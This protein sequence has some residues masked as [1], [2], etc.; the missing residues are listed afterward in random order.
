MTANLP[1]L[2]IAKGLITISESDK[3]EQGKELTNLKLQKILY[4]A[5]GWYL[6]FNHKALFEDEIEAWDYGPVVPSVYYKYKHFGSEKIKLDDK[7]PELNKNVDDFLKNIWKTFKKFSGSQLVNTTHA[8]KPWATTYYSPK[9][10]IPKHV[11]EDYF[12]FVAK[13]EGVN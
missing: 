8:E 11:I 3:P 12:K 2:D 9:K 7:K 10:V 5:Q 13:L 6:A 1:A 4:Y